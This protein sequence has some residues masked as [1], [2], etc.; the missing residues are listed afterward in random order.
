[1]LKTQPNF[2]PISI[3][4]SCSILTVF[5]KLCATH[6]VRFAGLAQIDDQVGKLSAHI[7]ERRLVQIVLSRES[8][9]IGKTV[10]ENR[11]RSR[12]DAAIVALHRDGARKRQKIG[13]IQLAV[14]SMRA[15]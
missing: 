14:R 1:M 8:D 12:F 7:L 3:G 10:K 13:D 5:E 11:F 4:K 15:L 6:V 9:M 2:T